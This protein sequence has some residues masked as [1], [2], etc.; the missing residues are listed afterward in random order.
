VNKRQE[1]AFKQRFGHNYLRR[2][3]AD[4]ISEA[5]KGFTPQGLEVAIADSW[6]IVQWLGSLP[7]GQAQVFLQSIP[8][9]RLLAPFI[10]QDRGNLMGALSVL[11]D[12]DM[13]EVILIIAESLPEHAAVLKAY[14]SWLNKEKTKLLT[15]LQIGA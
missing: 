15:S 9:I 14:P 11:N 10:F 8:S 1:V 6:S 7:P 2:C 5:I 3:L 4:I 13:E 12:I